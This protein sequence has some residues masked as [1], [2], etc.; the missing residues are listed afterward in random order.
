MSVLKGRGAMI[1]LLAGSTLMQTSNAGD[2]A[3]SSVVTMKPFPQPHA[4]DA[5]LLTSSPP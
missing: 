4:S 2:P 1:L 5:R 3:T